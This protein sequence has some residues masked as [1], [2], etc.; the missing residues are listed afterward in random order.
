MSKKL[1]PISVGIAAFNEENNIQNLLRSV[2]DQY[3]NGFYIKEIIV[4]SDGSTDKT[5]KRVEQIR[6]NKI[7]MIEGSERKGQTIRLNEILN[8]FS[9][10]IL[11]LLEA[12]TILSKK[13]FL[14][15]L[16]EPFKKVKNLNLVHCH[17]LPF[18]RQHGGLVEKSIIFFDS[19]KK[20]S[21][22]SLNN[23]N[24][25][26]RYGSGK[27]LSKSLTR[28][29]QWPEDVPEDSFGYLFCKNNE[30]KVMHQ[31][32]SV[33]Y[34]RSPVTLFDYFKK[35][36]RFN[37]GRTQLLKYF[38]SEL[39]YKEYKTPI[40]WILRLIFKGFF[41]SSKLMLTYLFVH[42]LSKLYLAIAPKFNPLWD[43]SHSTKKL[44]FTN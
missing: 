3:E 10:E 31:P 28:K 15:K 43:I 20:H 9:G 6:S 22:T 5:I 42:F 35:T 7:K 37:K 16:I 19:L 27:A 36:I 26:Y 41:L 23:G 40:I 39:I 30:L 1:I 33:V 34:Y 4:I 38:P 12:D 44:E 32:E 29:L 14:T 24:N 2:L 21:F 18:P 11:V 13:N 25:V 17:A 8:I